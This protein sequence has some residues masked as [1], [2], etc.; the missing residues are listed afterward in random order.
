MT[1]PIV[2]AL[3]EAARLLELFAADPSRTAAIE[4]MTAATAA[5]FADGRKVLICGNGGSACD[6]MHFAEEFTGKFKQPRP[7]LPAIAIADASHLTCVANDFGF[8]E[9]FAR[10]VAAYG[11]PGDICY[12]LS[13]SGNSPNILRALEQARTGGLITCAL[14]GGDGGKAK[15]M[16]DHECIVPAHTSERV[17][18]VHMLF[19]HSIIEGV[20]RRLFPALYG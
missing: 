12:V 8:A 4:A 13:T 20:E 5:A 16:A 11:K 17:Q 14:L 1:N 9:V 18:E 10:A 19:L 6:A 7:P 3:Q 2:S 15:G